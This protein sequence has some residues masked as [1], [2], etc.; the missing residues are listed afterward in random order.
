MRSAKPDISA[1]R[2]Q[3]RFFLFEIGP[4]QLSQRPLNGAEESSRGQDGC[5]KADQCDGCRDERMVG[6]KP[7]EADCCR[8]FCGAEGDVR[9]RLWA[10]CDGCAKGRLGAVGCQCDGGADGGCQN[11]HLRCELRAGVIG[12]EGRD[13]NPN[14]GMEG[15]P[16]DV[17]SWDLVRDE[18]H[19]EHDGAD[20]EN[21]GVAQ[22]I[23]AGR[24]GDPLQA[25]QQPERQHG[26]VDI[27]ARSEA[28]GDDKGRNIAWTEVHVAGILRL[29]IGIAAI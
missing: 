8:I 19:R 4:E 3:C 6:R 23:E 28:R 9:D 2:L 5:D 17:E 22:R 11:L 15:V 14:H 21:P 1:Q 18:L 27:E 25:L 10:G 24:Q 16:D 26:G 12:D 13:R 29:P 7:G 20:D